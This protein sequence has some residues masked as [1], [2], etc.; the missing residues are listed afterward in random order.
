MGEGSFRPP[1]IEFCDA[2][3][4]CQAGSDPC[5]GQGCDEATDTCVVGGDTGF[6][7]PGSNAPRGTGWNNPL[8]AHDEVDGT[9]AFAGGTGSSSG[10]D[11]TNLG[12]AI[13]SPNI[14]GVTVQVEHHHKKAKD[15]GIYTCQLIDDGGNLCGSPRSSVDH[16]HQAEA[17]ETLGGAADT[18][19]CALTEVVVESANFG[20][21]CY[22]T[23]TAGGGGNK[24]RVDELHVKVHFAAAQ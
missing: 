19:G 24:L 21:S 15:T 20:V 17:T 5:P 14:E 8:S 16:G 4:D 2:S 7:S 23:R 11:F 18:W 22:Y 13:S 12:V 10:Q 1:G 9:Y 3:L 6:L